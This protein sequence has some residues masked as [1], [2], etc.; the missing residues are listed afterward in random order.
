MKFTRTVTALLLA[1]LLLPTVAACGGTIVTVGNKREDESDEDLTTELTTTAPVATTTPDRFPEKLPSS[2]VNFVEEGCQGE[3]LIVNVAYVEGPVGAYVQ[4]SLKADPLDESIVDLMTLERDHRLKM[5]IG[6]E[7][8]IEQVSSIDGMESALGTALMAGTSEYDLLAGYQYY[9]LGMATKGYLLNLANLDQF[10]AN[11]I[12]FEAPYWATAY[13][14]AINPTGSYFWITG[15]LALNYLGGMYGT[16]V[17]TMLYGDKLESLYGS[18]YQIAREGKW[19]MDLL[20]EMAAA[21]YIDD[22]DIVNEPDSEDTYGFGYEKNDMIDALA[23]GMGVLYTYTVSDT[24]E[25]FF[26]FNNTHS[27]DI[28]DKIYTITH[29]STSFEYAD[30]D[31][32]NLMWAFADGKLMFTVNQ[33]RQAEQYLAGRDDFVVVPVPKYDKDQTSYI[34][35]VH[36]GCTVFGIT[37]CTPKVRQTAAALEFLCAYNSRDAMPQYYETLLSKQ[38]RREND[39]PEMIDL[40]HGSATTDFG[41]AWSR[42]MSDL[43]HIYRECAKIESKDVKRKIIDWE[44]QLEEIHERLKIHSFN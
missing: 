38:F 16:F 36:E 13:N 25:T 4:R 22:G 23:L 1:G 29:Q 35:P 3:D 42:S 37:Y 19:T 41:Y 32:D 40:I 39:A 20:T 10:D 12:D 21:C 17:N 33:L 34:T 8:R 9:A 7:L 5:Q 43:G 18:I 15:D 30:S 2:T 44:T 14:N 27:F 31:A 11:Y 28:S 24:G 26:T 6:L